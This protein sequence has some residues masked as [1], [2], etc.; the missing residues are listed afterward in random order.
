MI[1]YVTSFEFNSQLA[2]FVYWI[3]ALICIAVYLFRFVGMY[4]KDVDKSKGSYYSPELTVGYIL[5][6]SIGSFIPVINLFMLIFD[7]AAS[8]FRFIGTIL[9]I[10]LVPKARG[11]K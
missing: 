2:I 7:A 1:D 8:A 10:P 9:D 6:L 5:A 4:K 3:P 11:E